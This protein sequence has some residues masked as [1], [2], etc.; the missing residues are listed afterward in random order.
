M[1]TLRLC[2]TQAWGCDVGIIDGIIIIV[3][4]NRVSYY[5]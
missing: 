3:S 5:S 4:F 2:V 1:A